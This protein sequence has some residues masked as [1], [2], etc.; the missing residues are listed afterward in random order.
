MMYRYLVL[1]A[2]LLVAPMARA[3]CGPVEA[4]CEI[5]TGSYHITLPPGGDKNAPVLVFLHG[6]GGTATGTMGNRRLVAPMLD[7]GWAVIA[8]EGLRRGGDG[9][10]SWTFFP[11]WEGRDETAF[12]SAVVADA[13]ARFALDPDRVML[14]GFSAG[15]FMV[16]YLACAAPD[17]FAAYAP[18]SGGFWR[19]HPETCA[20]PVKLLHTHGWR[21]GT[22]PLEGRK[23]R[24]GAFQQGDIFAGLEIWRAAN[25]CADN[26]PNAYS[27]TGP[28]WRRKWTACTPGSALELAMWPGGHTLP[29]GWSDMAIDWFQEVTD[30]D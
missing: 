28:F 18:V 5:D 25:A 4:A 3:A 2:A 1:L 19:P 11:G 8:P 23:L 24:G 21:D 14:S 9:P 7:R 22:V 15:G 26:K 6:F 27:E 16:S 10:K 12:L 30:P 29:A 13:A 17:T 20:G